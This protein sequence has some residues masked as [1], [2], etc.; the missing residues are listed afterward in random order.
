MKVEDKEWLKN[1][2]PTVIGRTLRGEVLSMYYKAEMLLNG[3]DK[4]NKR[5][6]SC[7]YRG[8]KQSVENSYNK[9]LHEEKISN[10]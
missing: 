7:Q 10:G 6:C 4:I 9:W 8:L 2:F 5:G 1:V 3:A